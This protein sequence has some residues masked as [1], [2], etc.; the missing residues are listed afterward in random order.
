MASGLASTQSSIAE[1]CLTVRL[2]SRRELCPTLTSGCSNTASM[3][4]FRPVL[5][6]QLQHIQGLACT[7]RLAALQLTR[8]NPLQVQQQLLEAL[9]MAR[10]QLKILS[11]LAEAT[12]K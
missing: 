11:C 7:H 2:A 10:F 5:A 6:A 12:N 9:Q 4:Q 1:P 8:Y 3:L